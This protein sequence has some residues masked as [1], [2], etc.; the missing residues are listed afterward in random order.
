MAGW[1]SGWVAS[2]LL[3]IPNIVI[4]DISSLFQAKTP[5]DKNKVT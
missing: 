2:K 3:F 5:I 4:Q 1:L